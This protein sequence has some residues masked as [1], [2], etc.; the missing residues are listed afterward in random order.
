MVNQ[1][2]QQFINVLNLKNNI[3]QTKKVLTPT[4]S[5]YSYESYN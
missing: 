2:I 5:G 1:L 4:V 3:F